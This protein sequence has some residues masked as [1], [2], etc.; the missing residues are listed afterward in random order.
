MEEV[1]LEKITAQYY[2]IINSMNKSTVIKNSENNTIYG[3]RDQSEK[4]STVGEENAEDKFITEECTEINDTVPLLQRDDDP[5]KWYDVISDNEKIF[6]MFAKTPKKCCLL[7]NK[8]GAKLN[9]TRYHKILSINEK[10]IKHWLVYNSK[11]N[12]QLFCFLN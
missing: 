5:G 9:R 2:N 6:L 4:N 7:L 11:S 8:N 1:A 10:L 3:N 12:D